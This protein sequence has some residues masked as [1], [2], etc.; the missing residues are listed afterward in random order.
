MKNQLRKM[1][2]IVLV[3]TGAGFFCMLFQ[4]DRLL[5]QTGLL[6]AYTI[7][8]IKYQEINHDILLGYVLKQRLLCS[9]LI[10][11]LATTYL[12]ITVSYLYFL[13]FGAALGIMTAAALLRYGLKGLL[14]IFMSMFP[15]QIVLFPSFLLLSCVACS[16]CRYLYFQDVSLYFKGKKKNILM[17]Y[18]VLLLICNVVVIIG[19]YIES[20]VNPQMLKIVLRFF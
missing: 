19:C 17:K 12:G 13:L 4:Q 18:M 5:F 20:Y 15:H 8:P 3:G 7:S 2:S 6:D 16:L 1:L 9:L 11:L 10:S 14:F